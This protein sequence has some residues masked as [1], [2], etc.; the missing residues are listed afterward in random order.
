MS[1]TQLCVQG[2]ITCVQDTFYKRALDTFKCVFNP[3]I[4]GKKTKNIDTFQ[5]LTKFSN[6]GAEEICA[7]IWAITFAVG[8]EPRTLGPILYHYTTWPKELYS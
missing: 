5:A 3:F 8:I 2:T 6:H 7:G 1:W 4:Y